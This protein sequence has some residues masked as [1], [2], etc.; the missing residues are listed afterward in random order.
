MSSFHRKNLPKMRSKR[1]DVVWQIKAC[2]I[3][4]TLRMRDDLLNRMQ[5][6]KVTFS[7]GKKKWIAD[8]RT[9][10]VKQIHDNGEYALDLKLKSGDVFVWGESNWFCTF[11]EEFI[12]DM[13]DYMDY[14]VKSSP[15]KPYPWE[16]AR[17]EA[18]EATNRNKNGPNMRGH[19]LIEYETVSKEKQQ[20]N[21]DTESDNKMYEYE[22]DEDLCD[23]KSHADYF[24]KKE[25]QN[26][27]IKSRC[28]LS[29]KLQIGDVIRGPTDGKKKNNDLWIV[30]KKHI[31][32]R[33]YLKNYVIRE[34]VNINFYQIFDVGENLHYSTHCYGYVLVKKYVD[35]SYIV[36]RI[37]QWNK[38]RLEQESQA[39]VSEEDK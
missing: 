16:I 2:K 12:V 6:K 15:Q 4:K 39:V 14:N 34:D 38:A 18:R 29:G 26:N 3:G 22:Y 28:Y 11:G 9:G 20:S 27:I 24:I 36:G 30:S 10:L 19:D 1:C 21:G 25:M 13:E 23:N 37:I 5:V 32:R 31:L 35:P 7:F 33:T 17:K 8:H